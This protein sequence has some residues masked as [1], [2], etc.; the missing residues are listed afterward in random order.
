MKEAKEAR[1]LAR[2]AGVPSPPSG[3]PSKGH[4]L[5]EGPNGTPEG[6]LMQEVRKENMERAKRKM[7]AYF[8]GAAYE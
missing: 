4:R 6:T 7:V 1:E 2:A 5:D 3:G 8:N